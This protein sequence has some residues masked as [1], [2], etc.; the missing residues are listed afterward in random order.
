MFTLKIVTKAKKD[1]KRL[2][3]RSISDFNLTQNFI[4]ELVKTGYEGIPIKHKPHRLIGNYQNCY[5]CHIKT[6][7]LLIWTEEHEEINIIEI[8]RVGTHSD[9]F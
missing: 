6:D 8:I 1:L 4:K 9:L 5:E 7:L 3:K 2:K